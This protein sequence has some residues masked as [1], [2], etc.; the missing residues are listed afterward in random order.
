M[1]INTK[2]KI[3][4]LDGTEGNLTIGSQISA[5]LSIP[6]DKRQM[7]ALKAYTLALKFTNDEEV[8]L[9]NADLEAVKTEVKVVGKNFS[10]IITGQILEVLK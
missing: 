9:D 3:K 6:T 4:E 8:E 1:K 2:T 7:D 5:I 10:P